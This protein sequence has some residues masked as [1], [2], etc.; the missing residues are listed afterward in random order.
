MLLKQIVEFINMFTYPFHKYKL[1]YIY[2]MYSIQQLF[3]VKLEISLYVTH[4][5]H[6]SFLQ[7]HSSRR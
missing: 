6:H 5:V 2:D 7:Q 3:V 4:K 1:K